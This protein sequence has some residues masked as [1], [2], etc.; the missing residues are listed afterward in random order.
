MGP[1]S[2]IHAEAERA[3]LYHSRFY[4]F[5]RQVTGARTRQSIQNH[6]PSLQPRL[7]A[8]SE[9]GL[10]CVY[11]S[12]LSGSQGIRR[13]RLASRLYDVWLAAEPASWKG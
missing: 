2:A 6:R 5:K 3:G 7:A 12:A 4:L 10:K 11:A 13:C 8:F 9:I 1:E